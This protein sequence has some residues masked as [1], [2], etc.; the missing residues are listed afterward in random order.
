MFID[1]KDIPA[2][3]QAM[4]ATF[5]RPE[6]E[7]TVGAGER[8]RVAGTASRA[9]G[10]IRFAGHLE[11]TVS[12][13]CA[14]CNGAFSQPIGVEFSLLYIDT[15]SRGPGDGAEVVLREEDCAVAQLDEKGRIDLL[16]LAREQVYLALPMKPICR[17][18]CRGLCSRCGTDL[19]QRACN[20]S[21]ESADPR[22]AVL[23]KLKNRL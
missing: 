15:G 12:I 3:P 17:E 14:R 4:E 21:E 16:A 9:Q 8:V 23:A 18:T 10:G 22:L 20:C 13:R 6:M 7:G 2:F 11:T 5:A 1:T 19:N